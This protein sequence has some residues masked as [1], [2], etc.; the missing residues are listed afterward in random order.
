M[1]KLFR[2]AQV[3]LPSHDPLHWRCNLRAALD[4]NPAGSEVGSGVLAGS[5]FYIK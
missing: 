3:A 5:G 4:L 1:K 2:L